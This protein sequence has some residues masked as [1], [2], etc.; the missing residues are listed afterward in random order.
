[1]GKALA[2][3]QSWPCV[4][5]LLWLLCLLRPSCL[6]GYLCFIVPFAVLTALLI[7]TPPVPVVRPL[8]HRFRAAPVLIV[9]TSSPM[10]SL[11][12]AS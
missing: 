1:M 3:L 4:T 5:R 9:L 10:P 12:Y 8:G 6:L 2:R 11:S 7:P